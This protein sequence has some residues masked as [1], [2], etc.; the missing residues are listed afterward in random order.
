MSNNGREL[1]S[2]IARGLKSITK[3]FAPCTRVMEIAPLIR[4]R[5]EDTFRGGPWNVRYAC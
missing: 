2:R 4:A 1:R 3:T 5:I